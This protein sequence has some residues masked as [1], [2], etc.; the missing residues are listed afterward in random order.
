MDLP[1]RWIINM[2]MWIQI[3]PSAMKGIWMR[4]RI[5]KRKQILLVGCCCCN[6]VTILA[7][8]QFQAMA[9]GYVLG[10]AES[11]KTM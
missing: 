6:Q 2:V 4:I 5:R 9:L 7:N 3:C 1:R 11:F 8:G 10:T